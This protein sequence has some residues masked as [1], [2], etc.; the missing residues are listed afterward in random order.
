MSYTKMG[1][2][3]LGLELASLRERYQAVCAEKLSLDMSRGKPCTEQLGLSDE[4]LF[5]ETF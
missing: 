4:L 2:E 3:A 5:V 1:K